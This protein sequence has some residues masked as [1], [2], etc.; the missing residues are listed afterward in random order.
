MIYKCHLSHF[1]LLYVNVNDN[2][3]LSKISWKHFIRAFL[4]LEKFYI[5]LSIA[6]NISRDFKR[7]ILFNASYV[8]DAAAYD[9]G[10]KTDE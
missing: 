7:H 10:S 9:D 6:K 5:T 2:N 8:T 3:V 4:F 1:K